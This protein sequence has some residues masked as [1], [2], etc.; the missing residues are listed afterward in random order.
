MG[1]KEP[2]EIRR[3]HREELKLFVELIKVFEEVFEMPNMSIPSERHLQKLLNR[4]DFDAFV[5][6]NHN[7]VV[8]GLTTYLLEQYYSE[9]PLAYIYDLAVYVDH[10]R[11][12]IGT[13][14][15]TEV[16]KFYSMKGFEELF[17]QAELADG[18]AIEFYRATGPSEE[19]QTVYFAYPLDK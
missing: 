12:G 4:K 9:K 10:Q 7:T 15:V 6:L 13:Q 1:S 11:Q 17:V 19:E 8:G 14:L 16:K 3:L 5:A 2:I 18:H